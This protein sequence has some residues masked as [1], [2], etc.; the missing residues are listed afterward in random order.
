MAVEDSSAP[1]GL[2]LLIQDYPYALMNDILLF[3]FS[4]EKW[5]SRIQ[6]PLMAFDY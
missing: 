6:L 4:S 2:R 1:H 5:Q 3:P